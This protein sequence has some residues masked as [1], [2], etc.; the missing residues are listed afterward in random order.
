[1]TTFFNGKVKYGFHEKL[2]D[3]GKVCPFHLQSYDKRK[4][5]RFTESS[6]STTLSTW[7][8]NYFVIVARD[9]HI[10]SVCF[11]NFLRPG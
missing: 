8:L 1:M 10:G 9:W 11:I 3:N 2:N 7:Y 6:F 4:L 5:R